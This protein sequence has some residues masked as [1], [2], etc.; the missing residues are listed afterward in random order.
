MQTALVGPEAGVEATG[1]ALSTS[2]GDLHAVF[3]GVNGDLT[4]SRAERQSP[5]RGTSSDGTARADV[6]TLRSSW[7][8]GGLDLTFFSGLM[9]ARRWSR[10]LCRV[11]LGPEAAT[12][13][14]RRSSRSRADGERLRCRAVQQQTELAV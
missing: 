6:A 9:F 7:M 3:H 5:R 2:A 4:R 14:D 1:R 8:L 11:L 13:R 12:A 10:G